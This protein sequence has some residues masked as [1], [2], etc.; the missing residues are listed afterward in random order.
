MHGRC[1]AFALNIVVD[2]EH[3]NRARGSGR[4]MVDKGEPRP[5]N[6]PAKQ[7]PRRAPGGFCA[8]LANL[9]APGEILRILAL[10]MP[11]RGRFAPFAVAMYG[12]RIT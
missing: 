6:L 2:R 3:T 8:S 1:H 11:R 9:R 5:V 4:W 12:Q 7:C 10:R